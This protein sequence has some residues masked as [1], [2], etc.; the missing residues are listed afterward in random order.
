MAIFS[1]IITLLTSYNDLIYFSKDKEIYF[2]IDNVNIIALCYLS[3]KLLQFF[4][5]LDL[6]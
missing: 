6:L 5:V 2:N 3:V 4:D 1:Q